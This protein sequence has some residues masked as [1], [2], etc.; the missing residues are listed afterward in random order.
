MIEAR[1]PK[2]GTDMLKKKVVRRA[3]TATEVREL[4]T[5]AKK[6]AGVAKIYKA[7]K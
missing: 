2:K 6:R 7:L 4:E 5:L 1:L 3:W